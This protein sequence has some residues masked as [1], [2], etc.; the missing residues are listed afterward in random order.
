MNT[1]RRILSYTKHYWRRFIVSG[2]LSCLYGLFSASPAWL[3]QHLV[4]NVLVAKASSLLLPFIGI[5]ISLFIGKALCM[6][7]STYLLQWT[8]YMIVNDIRR[9]LFSRIIYFPISFFKKHETGDIISRFINDIGMLQYATSVSIRNGLRSIFEAVALLSIAL[10]QNV[11]L[12]SLAFIVAPLIG[13]AIKQTGKRIRRASKATQR[14]MGDVSSLLQEALVG[15]RSIKA[16]NGEEREHNRFASSLSTYFASI[17]KCVHYEALAPALVEVI[18]I[19]GCCLVLGVASHQVIK[20][21]ITPGQLSSLFAALLLAYQPIKRA[22]S[23]YGDIQYGVGAAQRIF[24]LLDETSNDTRN[25]TKQPLSPLTKEITLSN[26]SFSYHPMQMILKGVN[27]TITH[28]SRIGIVGPSGVG[29]ST[30]SDL[31]LRFIE[32][33]EGAILFDGTNIQDVSLKSLRERIGYVGQN[34][35]LFNDTVYANIA[36]AQPGVGMKDIVAACQ[37]AHADEFIRSLPDGYQT[38][39]GE[40]GKFLSGGQKQRITIARALLKQ[41][42]LLIF[43][44]ATSALDEHAEEVINQTITE[45]S[46]E[47]TVIV[48]SHRP[49]M[50]ASMDTIFTIKNHSLVPT[51]QL[52][53]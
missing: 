10:Y 38:I 36:Y 43:D 15:I 34:P 20:G 21:T 7:F 45:L 9:E 48:I 2:F 11:L 29:K 27:L 6:Y 53:L 35:F 46:R 8:G 33:G 19:S 17:M 4:D 3:I 44:E 51:K 40:N 25:D 52:N 49:A 18:A 39:V 47:T 5:F 42:D 26:I 30:L 24:A 12:A 14:D 37:Q 22:M 16:F 31:L 1:I 41:P 32:P 28:G 13:I 23:V 50:L